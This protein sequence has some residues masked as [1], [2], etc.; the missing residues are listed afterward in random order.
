MV[1]EQESGQIPV[2]WALSPPT[3]QG[4]F[5]SL[6]SEKLHCMGVGYESVFLLSPGRKHF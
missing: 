5:K 2:V 6:I 3:G 1:E 4:E